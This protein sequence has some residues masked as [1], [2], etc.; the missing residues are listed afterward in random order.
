MKGGARGFINRESFAEEL[1]T[2]YQDVCCQRAMETLALRHQV[3]TYKTKKVFDDKHCDTIRIIFCDLKLETAVESEDRS[4]LLTDDLRP[5]KSWDDILVPENIRDELT[6]FI[7][8]LKDLKTYVELGMRAPKG[9]L[10]YGPPRTG[11]TSLAKVVASE[12]GVNFLSLPADKLRNMGSDM[13]HHI[14]RVARK[15]APT[16]LFIDEIDAIG[17]DRV[18]HGVNSA[19][20]ALLDEMDGF[21]RMNDKPV[22]VMAA[23]NLKEALDLALIF[24][25]D[26][27]CY[28]PLPNVDRRKEMLYKLLNAHSSKFALSEKEVDSIADRSEGMSLADLENVFEAALRENIRS[29]REIQYDL[30]DEIFEKYRDG[31]ERE[32]SSIDDIEHTACHEAGHA[33]VELRYGRHPRYISVVA[34]DDHDGYV[35]YAKLGSHPTKEQLLQVIC[36]CLGGRAAEMEFGYGITPAAARDLEQA[37]NWAKAMVCQYGMYEDRVGLAVIS[38]EELVYNE[39]AKDLINEILFE[40]MKLAR[41]IITEKKDIV[42]RLVAEVIN[43][44][45][46]YL[47]EKDI[48]KIY[49]E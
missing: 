28:V 14:F 49:G 19:L 38:K 31:E 1:E 3:L 33:I 32:V 44:R 27:N 40:Q 23:T 13:V 17:A 16:I 20:N 9:I 11:K 22:F 25:F 8:V 6:T 12:S 46:K 24:R 41:Q 37:T 29:G 2:V 5:Q 15:Y 34:R 7:N 30:F 45:Q 39:K 35:E 18:S 47:T 10:L 36:R 48:L 42:E 21:V 26:I 4:I 43:S